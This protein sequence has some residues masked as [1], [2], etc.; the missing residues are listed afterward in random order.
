MDQ[1]F[2][3]VQRA[4]LSDAAL[5]DRVALLSISFD[6]QFDTPAI[7]AEHARKAGADPRVWHFLTGEQA[8]IERLAE[9]FGVSVFREGADAG[10][11]THTI[12]TAV[13]RP[14]GTLASV[15]NGTDWTAP[16]LL[17]ALPSAGG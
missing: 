3:A 6:P 12:R 2:A 16:A 10:S 7:L 9:S 5:R 8:E 11:I 4:V 14:D 15:V 13:I 1:N 17:Q